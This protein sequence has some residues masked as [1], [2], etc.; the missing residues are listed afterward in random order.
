MNHPL[1]VK[2]IVLSVGLSMLQCAVAAE[3]VSFRNEIAPILLE[4]CT[5]CHGPKKA[6]GGYRLDSFVQLQKAGDSG[7]LPLAKP[8]GASPASQTN[9]VDANNHPELLRRLVTTVAS[10]RMPAER[11]ALNSQAIELISRWQAEGSKFDGEDPQLPLFELVPAKTYPAAP[12]NYRTALPITAI[13]FTPDGSQVIAAG[14]HE[15]TVWDAAG[16]KLVRRVGNL[17]E[18]IQ[19][20]D[21]SSDQKTLAVAGGS[22]GHIGEVRL[23]NWE[24]GQ[25]TKS[26]GRASD[27]VQ[28]VRFQLAGNLIATGNSD[29]TVRWYDLSD[30]HLVRSVASH[31]DIVND[32]AWSPDG[33]RLA[34]ASRDKTAK[35]FIVENAELVAT[36]SAHADTVTGI[37]FND[38]DKE[39]TTIGGDKKL[40]RWQ[41]EDGK[42]LAKTDLAG[43][44]TRL[45]RSGANL[46][47]SL[48][49]KSLQQVE[50]ATSKMV[51]KQDGHS[52]WITSVASH[53]AS[54]R[55]ASGGLDGEI[56]LWKLEDGSAI[57]NWIGKP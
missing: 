50:L 34:S 12:E 14:Y 20:M 57:G 27:I 2:S 53:T 33:K 43:L 41:I 23:V 11:E 31:A 56:R 13:G 26:F 10:E 52:G 25:V 36:Y 16:G 24:S 29:G 5:S 15:L 35:V 55:V 44:P 40:H 38:G 9:P 21:W 30:S 51:R 37:C 18:R 49:S 3:P 22:P 17:P 32:I 4:N 42:N 47:I 1:F 6:E 45:H 39:V 8:Q 7:I 28:V 48:N 46:L 54:G 19:S